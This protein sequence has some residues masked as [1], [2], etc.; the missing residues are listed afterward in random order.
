MP[1][2]RFP[3][4]AA[5]AKSVIIPVAAIVAS[6]SV[7]GIFVALFGANPALVFKQMYR[8]SL[9]T[10]FSFQNTLQR[11]APLMLTAL[12]TALPARAGLIIIGG[13]GALVMGGLSAAAV[14]MALPQASPLTVQLSMLLAGFLVGGIWIGISAALRAY[15]GVNET[16]GSLLMNYIAIALFS[17]LVEGVLR[18]PASLNKPSTPPLSDA[19]MLGSLPGLDVHIGLAFGLFACVAAQVLMKWTWNQTI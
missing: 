14:G 12:C 10:W 11:A 17:H 4:L 5:H 3:R 13:E 15:R 7:F 2:D 6:L 16:I 1:L 8:G 18:D 9:G 19:I